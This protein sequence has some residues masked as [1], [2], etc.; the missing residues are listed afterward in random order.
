M[1]TIIGMSNLTLQT[2]LDHKQRGYTSKINR[3]GEHLLEVINEILDFSKIEAGK[4]TLENINFLLDDL[5]EHV[6]YYADGKTAGK[7]VRLELAIGPEV[8]YVVRGD[9]LRLSQVLVNLVSNAVKFT[10][11]GTV[12]LGVDV[13]DQEFDRIHLK[14]WVR[15]EGIGICP[16]QYDNLFKVFSQADSSVTREYGGSGLGLAICKKIVEIMGGE[17][18]FSSEL[19][20]GSVFYISVVFMQA[21]DSANV[22]VD[23]KVY[24]NLRA[25]LINV[26]IVTAQALQ[27]QLHSMSIHTVQY[28]SMEQAITDLQYGNYDL[29]VSSVESMSNSK[30]EYLAKIPADIRYRMGVILL[31]IKTASFEPQV[32][33]GFLTLNRPLSTAKFRDAVRSVLAKSLLAQD[34]HIVL[35]DQCSRFKCFKGMHVLVVEDNSF[36][37]ALIEE[38]LR[39]AGVTWVMTSDGAQAISELSKTRFDGVLMD[40]Q[41]PIMDGYTTARIIKKNEDFSDLPIIAMTANNLVG[42]RAKSIEAGMCDHVG[43]PIHVEGLF[44]SMEKWFVPRMTTIARGPV[45]PARDCPYLKIGIDKSI[46]LEIVGDA[47]LYGKMLDN[48]VLFYKGAAEGVREFYSCNDVSALQRLAHDMRGTAASIGAVEL[49]EAAR[50][51]ELC[52]T[53]NSSD[54]LPLAVEEFARALV[55]VTDGLKRLDEI[56]ASSR[57]GTHSL[58]RLELAMIEKLLLEHD[59]RAYGLLEMLIATVVDVKMVIRLEEVLHAIGHYQFE[60]AHDLTAA[61]IKDAKG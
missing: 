40:C 22:N 39:N 38:L 6:M 50:S 1:N 35:P 49:A 42:D 7:D 54:A 32:Q 27:N 17:I 16:A 46:G 23:E 15:D 29:V 31:D 43:K 45:S 19:G 61:I 58:K 2:N 48:F 3:A 5:L 53:S 12:T 18:G 4:L 59:Y 8:P 33:L 60:K 47:D 37:Q 44:A 51:L 20:V 36:N 28:L 14:F 41:M 9:S 10:N 26:D 13:I 24:G 34:S 57:E 25:M 30:D 52:A 55:T 56:K 11:N 21:T